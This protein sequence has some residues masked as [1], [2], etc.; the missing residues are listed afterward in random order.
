MLI[1]HAVQELKSYE[2]NTQARRPLGLERDPAG[3]GMN[4]KDHRYAEMNFE[5]D[6]EPVVLIVGMT[7]RNYAS[8]RK[9]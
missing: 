5:G 8:R 9:Y 3:G 2:E 1:T 6:R 4:W 7:R